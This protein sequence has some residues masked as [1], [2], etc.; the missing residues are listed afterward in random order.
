MR[1]IVVSLLEDVEGVFRRNK[2]NHAIAHGYGPSATIAR[3]IT[4]PGQRCGIPGE[5]ATT[6]LGD[7]PPDIERLAG[8]LLFGISV[9]QQS[10]DSAQASDVFP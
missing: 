9:R 3:P 1:R 2:D 6:E 8:S 7:K 4:V 10:P 5:A